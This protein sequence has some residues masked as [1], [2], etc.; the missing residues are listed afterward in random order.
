MRAL[1]ASCPIA[2]CMQPL[3][4]AY[5]FDLEALR[6]ETQ[7]AKRTLAGKELEDIGD[8]LMELAPLK[9][10][11]PPVVKLLQISMT[12]C[13]STAKFERSF[14]ALIMKRIKSYLFDRLC[15]YV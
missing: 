4:T 3:I 12:M 1:Q 10:A 13:V 8:V 11:F 2:I 15:D 14:S 5:E 6:S 9:L 7:I